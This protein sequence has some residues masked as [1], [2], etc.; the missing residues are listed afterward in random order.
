MIRNLLARFKRHYRYRS[1]ITGR[2]VSKAYAEAHPE[3]TIRE[4]VR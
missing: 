3:T 2:I 4:R 1:A